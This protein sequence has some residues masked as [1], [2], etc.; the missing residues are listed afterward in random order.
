MPTR[1]LLFEDDA[2]TRKLLCTFL[3]THAFE[4]LAFPSPGVCAL[5]SDGGCRCPKG[6]VCADVIIT[7]MKMPGMS[8]LELIRYQQEHACKAP[9]QNKAVISAALAPAQRQ[10][11][12]QLGCLCIGKPLKLA[13]LLAWIRECEARIS[14]GRE[15]TP[16]EFLRGTA[17]ADLPA[18]RCD[19]QRSS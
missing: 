14:P 19:R 8:G 16:V 11:F 13:A 17:A 4:V 18:P 12:V 7:D 1:I 10:E 5:V 2:D 15:L 9:P 3:E 6:C